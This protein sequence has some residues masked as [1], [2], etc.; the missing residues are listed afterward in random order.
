MWG[1]KVRVKDDTVIGAFLNI[2]T[3]DNCFFLEQVGTVPAEE[4]TA[5]VPE[6]DEHK[7]YEFRV[8]PVNEAGPGEASDPSK[9]VFTK[10]RRGINVCILCNFFTLNVIKNTENYCLSLYSCVTIY[11][12][13]SYFK[14]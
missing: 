8:I 6:L 10:A 1:H 11:M 14:N 13:A 5:V 12:P 7:D 2:D 3:N 4:T 9:N